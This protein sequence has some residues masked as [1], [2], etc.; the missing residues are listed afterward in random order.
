M[1][2]HP[3]SQR[4]PPRGPAPAASQETNAQS[5]AGLSISI[6]V[7]GD[8][9]CRGDPASRAE[10]DA[11][12][13]LS[14][15]PRPGSGQTAGSC[16]WPPCRAPRPPLPGPSCRARGALYFPLTEGKGHK[17]NLGKILFLPMMI[18]FCMYEIN[19]DMWQCQW[20]LISIKTPHLSENAGK[21]AC[22]PPTHEC[23][24]KASPVCKRAI[25]YSHE[26]RQ[27]KPTP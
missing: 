2:H 8:R 19:E 27:L 18:H 10:G 21:A 12:A 9:G 20:I 4:S 25:H 15:H 23:V 26:P 3:G 13:C 24:V 16:S 11:K 14:Q 5:Q 7:P 22:V 17:E 1:G 6:L